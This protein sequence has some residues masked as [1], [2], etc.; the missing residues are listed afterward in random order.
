MATWCLLM[1]RR[2][3]ASESSSGASKFSERDQLLS[4]DVKDVR[5]IRRK[6]SM[7]KS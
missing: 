4:L 7:G 6:E 5:N 3:G 2:R 1:L